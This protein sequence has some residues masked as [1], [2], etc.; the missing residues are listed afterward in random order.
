MLAR[1]GLDDGSEL[2]DLGEHRLRDLAQPM[3]VFQVVHPSLPRHFPP[4][5][6]LDAYPTNLPAQVTAFIGRDDELAAIGSALEE[7]RVV[8][9]TGVGGVGK[10]RLAVQVAAEVLPRYPGGAWL[11]ELGGLTDPEA[12]P[13]TVASV[14]AVPH[15]QGMTV[16]EALLKFVRSRPMLLV[17]DNCEHLLDGVARLVDAAVRAAPGLAVL[18]TSREAL[19]VSGERIFAVQPL[20]VPRN[21]GQDNAAD[22]DAVQLFV[23]RARAVRSAFALTAEN[24][25]GVIRICRRLDGIP[26]AIELAAARVR[27]MSP[28]EIAGRLDQRFHLLTGGAR[29]AASRHQTLR[30]A[31]DWSYDLLGTD[32]VELLQ[33]LSVCAGGF[34]I[35]AAE[36][37]G[38]SDAI[39]P[40]DVLDLVD[41]LVDKSLVAAEELHGTTRY[42]M[43]ETIRDYALERLENAGDLEQVRTRHAEHYTQFAE[44]ARA[45]LRSPDE[46]G[47]LERTERELDN[48]RGAVTWA[49]EAGDASLAVR[50]VA[51]LGIHGVRVEAVVSAWAAAVAAAP[52]ASDDPRYAAIVSLAA[53]RVLRDGRL[54]EANRLAQ[55]ALAVSRTDSSLAKWARCQVFATTTAVAVFSGNTVPEQAE[56]WVE[57][58]RQVAGHDEQAQALTMLCVQRMF[59]GAEGDIEAGEA[60]VR[61]ARASGS[62]TVT[63]FALLTLGQALGPTDPARAFRLLDE[64]VVE[65][66]AAANDWAAGVGASARGSVLM[67]W[68]DHRAATRAMLD[69]AMRCAVA[70]NRTSMTQGLLAIGALLAKAGRGEPA[71]VL[72]GYSRTILGDYLGPGW[73]DELL[74]ELRSLPVTLG[75]DAYAQ[76]AAQGAAMSDDEALV[77]ATAAVERLEG[78]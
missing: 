14:L 76:F 33:R 4:L 62:P 46:R 52:G 69:S 35:A 29:G 53:W 6:T 65:A 78:V 16:T 9:L 73:S 49:T 2:V 58:A 56:E 75:E 28:G 50:T 66:E 38:A 12:V 55:E 30:R 7:A 34:D 40:V 41:H 36:A 42:R 57:L 26:L 17:L 45:G 51:A 10:T 1:H 3:R 44:E 39:D 20:P 43:L 27:S 70:G 8:T 21:N 25:D 68:G 77:F 72:D 22:A 67:G 15:E 19:N 74:E 61:E 23:E 47:W 37:I 64:A 63:S 5:R 48:L 32:E 60:G 24:T 54:D 71:A 59:G 11:M 18:S 31:I 13:D